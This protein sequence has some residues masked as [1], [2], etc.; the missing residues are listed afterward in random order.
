MH[1]GAEISLP[2]LA[3]AAAGGS[4]NAAWYGVALGGHQSAIKTFF[5][6]AA[7]RTHIA[8][9][10][11]DFILWAVAQG[12]GPIKKGLAFQH[13]RGAVAAPGRHGKRLHLADI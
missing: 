2:S 9:A 7:A 6:D 1:P 4:A 13:V 10:S 8:A 11:G 5:E 3:L 12:A